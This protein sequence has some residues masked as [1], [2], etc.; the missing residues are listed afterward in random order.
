MEAI[1]TVIVT[2][3]T[4]V[5]FILFDSS[6]NREGHIALV[7]FLS[8]LLVPSGFW[9]TSAIKRNNWKASPKYRV[10]TLLSAWLASVGII[11]TIA[12]IFLLALLSLTGTLPST[13]DAPLLI[14]YGL[15]SPLWLPALFI[16]RRARG[17]GT[18]SAPPV[19]SPHATLSPT[20]PPVVRY[21]STSAGL[22]GGLTAVFAIVPILAV[23][24]G[25]SALV[26]ALYFV[27]LAVLF[28]VAAVGLRRLRRFGAF[29][30]GLAAVGFGVHLLRQMRHPIVKEEPVLLALDVLIIVLTLLSWRHLRPPDGA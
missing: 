18:T 6:I 20:P 4:S 30:A 19:G 11:A 26:P 8:I 5:L 29:A 15:A 2:L 12:F 24:H 10:I 13:E 27:G 16:E 14:G 23:I 21:A 9:A 1:I 25:G 3:L 17:R 7:I 28:W 22:A